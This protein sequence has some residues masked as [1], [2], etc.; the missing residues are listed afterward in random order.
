MR[1]VSN[2][3]VLTLYTPVTLALIFIVG[4]SYLG[5]GFVMPLRALYGRDLG[6]T[7]VEISLMASAFLLAGFLATPLIGWASD[8]FNYRTILALGLLIHTGTTLAYIVAQDP[9]FLIMLRGWVC[10]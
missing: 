6:A 5:L 8:R 2:E 4:I 10:C 3:T 1:Q 7:S 9:I